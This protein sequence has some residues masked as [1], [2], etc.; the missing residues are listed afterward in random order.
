MNQNNKFFIAA[1]YLV[2]A[3]LFWAGNFIVGKTAS[4][5]EIPPISLN[6]YSKF[7]FAVGVSFSSFIFFFSLGYFSKHLSKYFNNK[8]SWFVI[9]NLF[10][11]L[12]ISYGLFF[13]FNN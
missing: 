7:S 6:F 4:I 11:I 13:I 2:C 9:D 3:T 8:K 12:M 10:G 1:I 5:N